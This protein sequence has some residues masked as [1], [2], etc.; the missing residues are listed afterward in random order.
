LAVSYSNLR[1]LLV[2]NGS[3]S[4]DH[5]ILKQ[6]FPSIEILVLDQNYGFSGGSNAG[7]KHAMSGGADFVW[8]LNNDATVGS[9]TLSGLVQ[10]A[11]A[12]P[13]AGALG[14]VVVEGENANQATGE[15]GLGAI[16]YFK[17]KTYLQ[18]LPQIDGPGGAGAEGLGGGV[19]T[20]HRCQWLSGSNLLLRSTALQQ[21]GVFDERYYLYFEDV[22]LC[23]RLTRAGFACL[24][25]PGF[26]VRHVGNAST[27]GGLSLWRAYYHTRNRLIFF[28]HNAPPQTRLIALCAILAHFLRHCI[29]LPLKGKAGRAKLYAEWLGV[30]DY[31]GGKVG[32][33][34]CLDWCENINL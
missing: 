10:I 9:D 7:L 14:A 29:S 23:L 15:A 16:N 4:A 30:K 22:D 27:Q 8:L 1:I 13:G 33:A 26:V 2:D 32:R 31:F 21:I 25:V 18:R 12:N 34:T 6:E 19:L 24:L 5:K 20:F 17:A 28:M 3:D 11:M